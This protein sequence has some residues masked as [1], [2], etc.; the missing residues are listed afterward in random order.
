[1]KI[2]LFVLALGFSLPTHAKE[3]RNLKQYQKSTH[4]TDL[5]ASDWLT[6]DRKQNTLVWQHANVYNLNNNKPQEYQSIIQ[7]RDFYIWINQ[8]LM[9]KGHEVIWQHMA[10]YISCKLR[11]ME[12]FPHGVFISGKVKKYA[13]KASEAVFDNAFEDLKNIFNSNEILINDQAN[14]WDKTMLQNEQFIWIENIIKTIDKKSL[15]QIEHMAEG[16]FL[17]ALMVPK[18]IRFE[19]D[20]SNPEERFNYAYNIFRPYFKTHLN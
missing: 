4:N 19:G 18:E 5:S 12:T 9:A 6:S 17:Y 13:H 20:I 3:W 8:E 7:R 16:K 11:L 15:K 2:V 14:V 10:H 1:M